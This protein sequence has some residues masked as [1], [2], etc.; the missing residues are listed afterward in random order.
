MAF[1]QKVTVAG[2]A[3][4]KISNQIKKYTLG[5]LGFV[6]NNAGV[7][8]LHRALEP[9]KSLANSIQ[10][11]V[12]V[13]QDLTGFKLS[14]VSAGDVVRVDIFKNSHAN[15]MVKLYHFFIDELVARGV[16]EKMSYD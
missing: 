5:D 7:Y 14:T 13:N 12:S 3:T 16:L 2:D 9:E 1:N 10:L 11:K 8:I 6:T 15:D 4:Y